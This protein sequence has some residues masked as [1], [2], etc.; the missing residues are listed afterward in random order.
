MDLGINLF[1]M[2]GNTFI[3]R[4]MH[5]HGEEMIQQIRKKEQPWTIMMEILENKG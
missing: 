3:N 4:D 5:H 1:A 2:R